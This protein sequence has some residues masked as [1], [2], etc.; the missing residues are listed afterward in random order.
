MLSGGGDYWKSKTDLFELR[1]WERA[2]QKRA[3]EMRRQDGDN[4]CYVRF[5]GTEKE[6]FFCDEQLEQEK[7]Q[8]LARFESGNGLSAA[9]AL[10]LRVSSYPDSAREEIKLERK[11]YLDEIDRQYNFM[12]ISS[13]KGYADR[14]TE[15]GDLK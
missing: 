15:T 7:R 5:R 6:E 14:F 10:K 8:D 2:I 1:P 3:A 9:E 11:K 12:H 4:K 13:A